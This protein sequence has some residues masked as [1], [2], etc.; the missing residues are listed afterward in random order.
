MQFAENEINTAVK[1]VF[2]YFLEIPTTAKDNS[3]PD[4]TGFMH[5][6]IKLTSAN[7]DGYIEIICPAALANK[8]AAQ[9]F[10]G[11]VKEISNE[12]AR[13]ALGEITNILGGNIKLVLPGAP[14]LGLPVVKEIED[15]T[16]PASDLNTHL[17]T[18][19]GFNSNLGP[20]CLC[21]HQ[22]EK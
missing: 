2:D 17:L 3:L 20:I 5:G 12:Q 22:I 11:D 15:G 6:I 8:A 10:G 14:V 16:G 1:T 18:K 21:V 13:D 7:W 19:L 4:L 9:M